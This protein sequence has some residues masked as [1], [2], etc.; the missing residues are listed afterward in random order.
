M[1]SIKIIECNENRDHLTYLHNEQA[2]VG[3]EL[4]S[5]HYLH[6]S[7][8]S[9]DLTGLSVPLRLR[10]Q[11]PLKPLNKQC[12]T[13]FKTLNVECRHRSRGY[14]FFSPE[15]YPLTHLFIDKS[16]TYGLSEAIEKG[17]LQCLTHLSISGCVGEE[18]NLN[19]IFQSL[20]PNLK[21]F[22]L[23]KTKLTAGD[24]RDLCLACNGENRTPPNLTSL[25][26][27]L[28]YGVNRLMVS[29]N[30]FAFSW[31]HLKEFYLCFY[32]TDFTDKED[33]LDLALKEK[34]KLPNLSCF[35]IQHNMKFI[36]LR[37][38]SAMHDV[39]CLIFHTSVFCLLR[40]TILR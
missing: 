38:T 13:D 29:M 16:S 19:C 17:N 12:N 3:S 23:L 32:A 28:P 18:G 14:P 1:K 20:L 26:L 33:C 25:C 34:N 24:L 2:C 8:K 11:D 39:E 31:P 10:L 40:Y 7:S 9:G 35:G 5:L 22:N 36:P 6:V 30:L 15:H 4:S 21:H 37:P 27:S